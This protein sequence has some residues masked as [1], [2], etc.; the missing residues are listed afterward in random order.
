MNLCIVYK[1]S[2][3]FLNSEYPIVNSTIELAKF[4]NGGIL[5]F[6]KLFLIILFER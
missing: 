2:Y 1:L 3:I 4:T 6:E 5:D